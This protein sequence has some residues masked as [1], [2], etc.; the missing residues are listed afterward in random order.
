MPRPFSAPPVARIALCAAL[1]LALWLAAACAWA[2][3]GQK[4]IVAAPA[5]RG[6]ETQPVTAQSRRGELTFGM[7]AAFTGSARGLGVEYFRGIMAGFEQVNAQGG[8]GGWLLRLAVLDDGYDPAP[9]VTNTIRFVEEQ[10]VFGLLGYV[11]TPTTARVLPLVKRYDASGTA[12]YFPL[13]GADILRSPGAAGHVINLRASYIE[14]TR[15]LVEALLAAGKRRIAVFHQADIYGRDGWDGVRR[16]LRA[17]NMVMAGEAAYRR[18]AAF[19]QDFRQ[20][21]ALIAQ[22]RPDA[23]VTVGTA[24][25]CAAF[26]RDARNA[27]MDAVIATLS[28]ADADNVVKYLHAQSRVSGRDYTPGL[29]FSQVVPSY[30]DTSLAA[31]RQYR[32]AMERAPHTLPPG[33]R[34]EEYQPHQYSF[35]SFEGYLAS[36][37]LAEAVRRMADAPTR[38]RLR[39][40][41]ASM[42]DFEVGISEKVGFDPVRSQGLRHTYL[43]VFRGG[44]F[45]GVTGLEGERP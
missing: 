30:E 11:G 15:H 36:Q 7:S 39:E 13:T 2:A 18:G 35:V 33:L 4:G 12:L 37:V 41:L 34:A 29:V 14:E 38:Q 45:Q 32:L 8:A 16:A 31:V 3:P 40:T 20:E 10:R 24:P 21:V 44:R 26:I 1:A 17:R 19:T 28:F 43:A 25:A 9:A 23:V 22:A 5:V 42:R 6:G 27:G